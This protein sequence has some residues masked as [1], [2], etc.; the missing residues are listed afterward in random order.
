MEPRPVVDPTSRVPY[1]GEPLGD[2]AVS[3]LRA[4]GPLAVLQRWYAEAVG[5]HRVSEPAAM[6]LASVDEDGRPNARTVLLKGLDAR[7]LA[8]YTNLASTKAREVTTSPWAAV[9]L[10]WH[11]MFR[12]VRARGRVVPVE[13]GEADVYFATRPRESQISAWASRQSAPISSRRELEDGVARERARWEGQDDVPR[14]PF[15]G[16]F[17]LRPLEVE[18]WV[19][20]SNRLHDRVAFRAL[21]GAPP[22]LDHAAAWDLLRLQP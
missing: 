22:A 12:Q 5:D 6:V 17:R 15:W 9:V 1:A 3:A 18:L 19:G 8:F 21:D 14:P 16:G 20:H 2:D 7:G 4:A 13:D 10:P 11:P